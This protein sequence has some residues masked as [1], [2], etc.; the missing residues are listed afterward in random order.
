MFSF[1]PAYL[2]ASLHIS[3]DS[4][5]QHKA[6]VSLHS[7]KEKGDLV[8]QNEQDS[9]LMLQQNVFAKNWH[10]KQHMVILVFCEKYLNQN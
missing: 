3:H 7:T 8:F 1:V 5:V 9:N 10:L 6:K 2:R 4:H